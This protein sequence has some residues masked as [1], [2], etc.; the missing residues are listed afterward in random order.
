MTPLSTEIPPKRLVFRWSTFK[1]LTAIL[2]FLVV[3]LLVEYF[4]VVYA[5]NLGVEDEHLLEGSFH[6]PGSDLKITISISPLFHLIPIAVTI[7]LVSSWSYLTKNVAV[8]PRRGFD[9]QA[10]R[11]TKGGKK[12]KLEGVEKLASKMR[13]SI[14]RF[15]RWILRIKGISF[16]WR[17]IHFARATIR[18]GLTVLLI[19]GTFLLLIS[20][21]L[22]P[23]LTYQVVSNSYQTNP[24]LL[25]AM[26]TL[27][28]LGK[29]LADTLT[30]IGWI[31]SV[32]NEALLSLAPGFREFVLRLGGSIKP[33]VDLD[34]VGKYIVLQN[35]AAWISAVTALLY[36]E[37]RRGS[38]R[39]SRR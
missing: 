29:G 1:G 3:A 15:K 14:D 11:S 39:Y 19:F 4:V 8:R 30:P 35:V 38:Y 13:G 21:L 25:N 10:E 20:L 16:L 37:Y 12:S 6:F 23:Q 28:N 9:R 5:A 31:S 34:P 7:S 2:L 27:N 33:L 22:H 36:I 32:S 17:R 26:K 24:A 18:S